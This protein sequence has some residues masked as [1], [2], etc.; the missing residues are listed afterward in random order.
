MSCH[1]VRMSLEKAKSLLR[2]AE[3]AASRHGGVSLQ[4]I[5]EEFAV[6]H[7]TAQRMTKALEDMFDQ[8]EILVD[9]ERRRHWR[10]KD[11]RLLRLQGLRDS[12]LVAL[13]MGIRRAERD[14][15]THDVK[16]LQA[17]RDRLLATMPRSHARRAEADA[18]AI[19][20]AHGFASRPGP[21]IRVAPMV[22]ETIVEALKG[23]FRLRIHYQTPGDEAARERVVEPYGLL[24]GTR[25]YL[26]AKEGD[27]LRHFRLDRMLRAVLEPEVFHR[28]SGF[29]L[30]AHAAKAFGSF[31]SEAEQAEVVWRFTPEAADAASEF[32]F[33]PDQDVTREQDGALTIRFTASGWLEMA[34]HLYQWGDQVEV[35][36]REDLRKMVEPGRRG[37]FPALP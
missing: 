2:L 13:D 6:D 16:A 18:E 29:D 23:P 17:L 27:R 15:A 28:D 36:A 12:E 11:S 14:G 20:E 30:G 9:A 8:V 4:Q 22:L 21:R 10:L 34:W 35:L 26:V 3:L 25:R 33:H 5:T 32:I 31:H 19:L 1:G 37:G 24:L 7:R